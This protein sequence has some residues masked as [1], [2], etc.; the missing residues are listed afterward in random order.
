MTVSTDSTRGELAY[1]SQSGMPR[2]ERMCSRWRTSHKLKVFEA[3][4]SHMSSFCS[5]E[6]V[7]LSTAPCIHAL[8]AFEGFRKEPTD[9]PDS[10]KC[11]HRASKP[12]QTRTSLVVCP[13]MGPLHPL[14]LGGLGCWQAKPAT[15][16]DISRAEEAMADLPE[17]EHLAEILQHETNQS[18]N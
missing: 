9:S 8:A 7:C 6:R 17:L 16:A 18:E 11:L 5:A 13:M 4:F 15:P 2:T 14:S 3:N 12:P 10:A 1:V